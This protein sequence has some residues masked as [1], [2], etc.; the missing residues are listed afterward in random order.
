MSAPVSSPLRVL[1]PATD[2]RSR[3]WLLDARV[4]FNR[5][6]GD[7]YWHVRLEA[8]AIAGSVQ[9]GQFLMLSTGTA[10]R[11][12]TAL[13]RPM[14][15][16][17]RDLDQGW[18]DVVY[19][20]VGAGSA[21]LTEFAEGETMTVVGP[22]GR[23][24]EQV[25]DDR[26][27]VVIGRGIGTCSLTLLALESSR[28]GRRVTALLSNRTASAP[29]GAD[30]LRSA[31]VHVIV[32]ADENG[33]SAL[34]HVEEALGRATEGRDVGLVVTCG[35]QRLTALAGRLGAQL[36]ADVQVAVEAHMACGIGYC[37]G[38]STGAAPTGEESPLVCKDGAVF[39]L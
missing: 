34:D 9:P 19:G 37:H 3:P 32:V 31:G 16:Y 28:S 18:V 29:V 39:R 2:T 13:P 8:P 33:T 22:L 15:V 25:P 17:D 20:V 38:C 30:L 26:D 4:V 21:K 7:R 12:G 10:A 1:D 6:W 23:P 5:H 27:V 24:F 35:S 14:A 11:L 36:G